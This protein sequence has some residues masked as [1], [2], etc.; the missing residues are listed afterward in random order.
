M[1]GN[2]P[3]NTFNITSKTLLAIALAAPATVHPSELL[4]DALTEGQW[5]LDF[6]YRIELVDE[7]SF[8]EDAEASTLRT[9]LHYRTGEWRGLEAFVEFSDVRH[10]GLDDFNAGAGATPARVHFPVVADP[11]DTRLNQAWLQ[12][13]PTESI[14]LRAGRQRIKLDNDRF[15]GNVGWRQNEQTY[16]SASLEWHQDRWRLFYGYVAQ[17]NRIFD[18]NVPAGKHDHDTHLINVSVD[19]DPDH[20]LTG[21]LYQIEDEDQQNQ[22]NRTFGA[23]YVGKK[24][25]GDER[26]LSWLAE[27]ARQSDT[28]DN[29][30]DYSA[31]YLHLRADLALNPLF[32]PLVGFERLEG[33]SR[34]GEAFRTPL[35]TLHAFNGWA[36]RFLTTPDRGLDD[37]YAGFS[38]GHDRYGW[39]LIWHRFRTETGSTTLG[40]EF[41]ASLSVSLHRTTSLLFKLAHV[42]DDDISLRGVT[43][44]WFALNVA[45]P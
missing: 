29:P 22:S 8:S 32:R 39:H 12:F 43:K 24:S 33:S 13:R 30:V 19:L 40:D 5:G 4:T 36:D 21:Y 18:S 17:A 10:V 27:F 44:F 25:M 6:R 9:R 26:A 20:K 28:G 38:G 35:A 1:R 14:A 16:D 11:E 42:Q 2:Q 34:P 3:M 23:R 31:N 45:L 41:D 7:D 37:F 15:V